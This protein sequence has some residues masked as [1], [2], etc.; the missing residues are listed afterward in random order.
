M[1]TTGNLALNSL[2]SMTLTGNITSG[3]GTQT[4]TGP[5]ILS[6][7][8]IVLASTN[9]AIAF[10]GITSSINGAQNLTI[11]SGSGPITLGST[12]GD[13][14]PIGVLSLT[15][16]SAINIGGN[17]ANSGTQTFTGPVVL[18]ADSVIS[19]T[20][21]AAAGNTISFTSTINGTTNNTESLTL[22]S[23][24]SGTVGVT[25][26]RNLTITNSGGTTFS[27]AVTAGTQVSLTNTTGTILFSGTLSTATLSVG[28]QGFN[29]SL[30]AA[31]GSITNAVT[32]GNT[33]TLRLGVSG[34]TQTYTG[35]FTATAPSSVTLHGTFNASGAVEIGDAGTGI[36]LGSNTIIST[37]SG[38]ANLTLAGAI[39]GSGI[40]LS[41]SSGSGVI[42]VSRAIG[43]SGTPLSVLAIAASGTQTGTVTVSGNIYAS[44][45]TVNSGA[46]DLLLTGVT[47]VVSNAITFNNTGIL[48]LGALSTDT[49]TFTAGATAIAPIEVKLAGSF[50][51]TSASYTI[52]DADTPI[53][54]LTNT[55][56]DISAALPNTTNT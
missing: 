49:H 20:S 9:A 46:Y 21:S 23:G 22:N 39:T 55:S 50:S 17:I 47:K 52:G 15:S 13:T 3:S 28:S 43:A 34:G 25:P 32:F 36:T 38:N 11:T 53:T 31:S 18:T 7:Q 27:G 2:G 12:I 54:L 4:Y 40:N 37:A 30:P 33:G 29:L 14:T 24:T 10:S 51:S 35:G 5:V 56:F 42:N 44:S 19:T 1:T 6:G 45:L 41:L 26:L 16:S 48:Q 8:A